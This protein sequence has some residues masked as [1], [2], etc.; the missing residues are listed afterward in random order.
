M[1]VLIYPVLSFVED[2]AELVTRDSMHIMVSRNNK[3]NMLYW[4]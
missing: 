4:F 2:G 1:L 3:Q